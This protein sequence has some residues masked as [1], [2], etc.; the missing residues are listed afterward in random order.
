MLNKSIILLDCTLR[1]GGYYNSWDFS[2]ELIQDYLYAMHGIGV[3]YVELGFR[4]L[5]N[6]GFK[7]GCAYTTDEF[8]R[9]LPIPDGLKLGVMV[10]ASELLTN[11]EGLIAALESLFGPASNSP[12]SL[13]RVACHVHEFKDVL[14]AS[15]WLKDKGYIVGFNI[16]QVADCKHEEIITLSKLASQ[17]P[18]NVLYFA[19]SMGSMNPTQI[20]QIIQGFKIGW[21]GSL[22]IHTHDNMGQ[23][24]GNS[25][26][27]VESGDVTWVDGTVTGMGRGAGNV[28]TEYLMLGLEGYRKKMPITPLLKVINKY[29]IPLQ[30]Q[31]G[32]GS[33][34]YYYQ[35]GKFSIHPSYIQEMLRDNRYSEADMLAVI[36]HLKTEGGKKYSLGTLE[37]ARHFYTGEPRGTWKAANEIEGK[38]VLILGTGPGI[39]NH[40]GAIES[41][42]KRHKPYVIALN[43]QNNIDE[44]MINIRAACHPV[45]LLADCHEHIN[46]PQPLAAP[47]SMLPKDIQLELETKNLLDFGIAIEA[48]VFKF[49]ENFCTLPNSLVISYAL[50]IAT[51]GKARRILLAGF[52]GYKEGDPRNYEMDEL[53]A[54]YGEHNLAREYFFITPTIYRVPCKSVYGLVNESGA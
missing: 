46:L 54:L 24:L 53:F 42:I 23:A 27:A 4:S 9:S 48:G 13:V 33:N 12:V 7:G 17:Y 41:Y 45:R 31:Y 8:I 16:M 32:W 47:V 49:N 20:D 1:D 22:G 37:A 11:E 21:S 51:S 26:S 30:S 34:P 28:K 39:V 44:K 36:E 35:A 10:N 52:D 43:T 29:F 38:E 5:H 3:D 6:E 50:A 25:I 2:Y 14:P 18:L 15:N 19:D 40:R